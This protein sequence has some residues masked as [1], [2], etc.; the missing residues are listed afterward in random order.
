MDR[1][2]IKTFRI[3]INL[4]HLLAVAYGLALACLVAFLNVENSQTRP[5][6]SLT[7][8]TVSHDVAGR[9]SLA[10]SGEGLHE[11][12]R[13]LYFASELE[14]NPFRWKVLSGVSIRAIDAH[15]KFALAG[16]FGN[17][18][19][20]LD[21]RSSPRPSVVDSI[22]LPE[23]I[24]HIVFVENRALIGMANGG[25]LAVVEIN[26]SGDLLIIDHFPV[27]GSIVKM[28][29]D[30]QF[31]YYLNYE[32]G[33]GVVDLAAERPVPR[34]VA[35]IDK[36]WMLAASDGKLAVANISGELFLFN[37]HSG[38]LLEKTGVLTIQGADSGGI[39]GLAFTSGALTV[40]LR[41]RNLK[42]F[43]TMD[44]PKLVR[45][46][47]TEIPGEPYVL[48]R[49]PGRESLL[50]S[51]VAG[52][53]AKVDILLSGE[54][55]LKGHLPLPTTLLTMDVEEKVVYVSG[56]SNYEG[57]SAVNIDDI[58]KKYFDSM[59]YVD[60]EYHSLWSWNGRLYGFRRD[61][62]L[63]RYDKDG[64]APGATN[65]RFLLAYDDDGIA[66]YELGEDAQPIHRGSIE[67]QGVVLGALHVDGALFVLHKNGLKVFQG[68]VLRGI[69]EVAELEIPGQPTCMNILRSGFLLVA[70][71]DGVVVLD[72]SDPA[73]TKIIAEAKAPT[74]LSSQTIS[75][76]IV[77]VGD[78]AYVSEG[79]GGVYVID[80]S[81]P[82]K[83]VLTQI[84]DTPGKARKM[85][86]RDN[87]LYVA[88]SDMGVFL[89]DIA[90]KEKALPIGSLPTPLSVESLAV[91]DDGV[92]VS[93]YPAGTVKISLPRR[94]EDLALKGK[95]EMYGRVDGVKSKGY[96]YLYDDST[97]RK[98]PVQTKSQAF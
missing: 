12:V 55:V 64:V 43:S 86:T 11:H 22:D 53:I 62:T 92:I 19:I 9:Q 91:V 27:D 59:R 51:M 85:T 44:W 36:P 82:E 6:F 89:I 88:D 67:T 98:V 23:K 45:F 95:N 7:G 80:V 25:G 96:A 38:G 93:N 63:F 78:T 18:L 60:Q 70:T 46:F 21:L 42:T 56:L 31:V 32:Q 10:F 66:V 35:D 65:D 97:Y 34:P 16:C 76:N 90:D 77:V 40:A 13:G 8:G 94:I 49:V 14:D 41:G 68:S 4:T 71:R 33:L 20:S 54:G 72:V 81:R 52:G 74:H 2:R 15:G 87:I 26:E 47:D 73:A 17:K 24:K 29:V 48:M 83:P 39:R 5:S 79:T 69:V 1:N 61:G 58:D 57:V 30:G 75:H 84:I 28:V 3:K 37:L 50:V